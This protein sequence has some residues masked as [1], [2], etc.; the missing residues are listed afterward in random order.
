MRP[1]RTVCLLTLAL[2]GAC[3]IASAEEGGPGPGPTP[4]PQP[5]LSLGAS[6]S[7]SFFA[8]PNGNVVQGGIA[9]GVSFTFGGG[10]GT[11]YAGALLSFGNAA[12]LAQVQGTLMPDASVTAN[13]A[14]TSR[15]RSSAGTTLYYSVLLVAPDASAAD[16]IN[17]LIAAG[18]PLATVSGF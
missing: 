3:G 18:V 17:S 1:T 9:N 8:Y 5:V 4:P 13:A 2:L 10:A 15:G 16:H 7:A 12:S 14:Q 6:I 11:P